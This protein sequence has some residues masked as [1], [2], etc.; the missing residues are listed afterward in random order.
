MTRIVIELDADGGSPTITS[1][2][3]VEIV[4]LRHGKDLEDYED[5]DIFE[6]PSRD[7]KGATDE[8]VGHVT[9]PDIDRD[10]VD[11]IFAVVGSR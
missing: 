9:A 2:V 3:P 1:D 5:D 4:Q 8:A 10:W 11:Q 7:L 6:V